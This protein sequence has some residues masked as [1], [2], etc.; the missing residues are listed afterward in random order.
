MTTDVL[1]LHSFHIGENDL[2]RIKLSQGLPNPPP[3]LM[4]VQNSLCCFFF[5]L[6]F[7]F[8]IHVYAQGNYL[9]M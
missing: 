5:L 3:N 4:L 2:M 6:F 8:S 9:I 7:F 1:I